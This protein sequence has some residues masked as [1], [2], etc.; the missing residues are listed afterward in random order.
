[1]PVARSDAKGSYMPISTW[2][3]TSTLL[4]FAVV[5]ASSCGKKTPVAA[6]APPP[7]ATADVVPPPPSAPAAIADVTPPSASEEERFARMSLDELNA[8]HPLAPAFFEYDSIDLSATGRDILQQNAIWMRRWP[9]T[10]V[11]V[12]G[13]ADERGTA[14]YNLSLGN[15]RADQVKTYLSSLGV[16]ASRLRVVSKGKEQPFCT[17]TGEDCWRQNRRAQF[18][19]IAK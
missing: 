19:V 14:E 3:R 12:E 5:A 7:A 18:V 4:L 10:T 6:V 16:D 2:I 9:S 15:R 13:H 11:L 1:M 17:A 8:T